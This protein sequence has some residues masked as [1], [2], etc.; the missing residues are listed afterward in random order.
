MKAIVGDTSFEMTKTTDAQAS[1]GTAQWLPATDKEIKITDLNPQQKLIFIDGQK[2]EARLVNVDKEDKT[3]TLEING[4]KTTVKIKEP[5]DDLLHSMGLDNALQAKVQDI[6]APMPGLVLDILVSE[7][8]PVEKGEKVLV[9]EAMKMEN[10][11]KSPSAGTVKRVSVTKGTAVDKN[12]VLI[13]M[14]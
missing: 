5:M 12:Q 8:Q 11:I 6:K 14:A 9:L 2:F 7:G 3:V 13:E 1:A 10:V 4:K